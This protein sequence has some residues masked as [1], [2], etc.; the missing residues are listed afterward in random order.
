MRNQAF[1]MASFHQLRNM[2]IKLLERVGI[3]SNARFHKMASKTSFKRILNI[4]QFTMHTCNFTRLMR[5]HKA[6]FQ[7][8]SFHS[9]FLPSSSSP[10]HSS[11]SPF[12]S[13]SP[14][15]NSF[16]PLLLSLSSH[17][18]FLSSFPLFSSVPLF[19]SSIPLFLSSISLFL[20]SLPLSLSPVSIT[21]YRLTPYFET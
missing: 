18:R 17:S 14:P 2:R 7:N 19:L 6:S 20:T 16:S 13:S 21:P 1:N 4:T 9:S 5:I 8:I 3:F 11:S 12:H 15:F 10:F